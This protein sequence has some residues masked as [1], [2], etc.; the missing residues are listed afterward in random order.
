MNPSM[1]CT[2]NTY[3][4][5]LTITQPVTADTTNQAITFTVDNFR[6]PYSGKPKTGFQILTTDSYGGNIDSSTIA[7]I[8]LSVQATDWASFSGASV[9]RGDDQ[10]TVGEL[11]LGQIIFSLD[12]PVDA[13]CRVKVYF[14]SDMPITGDLTLL[15]PA[16][17][18]FSS[19]SPS[20][21]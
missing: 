15:S 14:P 20:V 16:G 4:Q 2:Y 6:N 13:Y 7:G 8:S 12:F 18:S 5:K 9:Q 21:Q 11:S 17:L 1:S 19:T 10:T 3:N